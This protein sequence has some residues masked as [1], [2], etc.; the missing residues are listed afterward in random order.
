[1]IKIDFN[2]AE[3]IL[4]VHIDN[5]TTID[6]LKQE[7]KNFMSEFQLPKVLKILEIANA[8]FAK[9]PIAELHQH[10]TKFLKDNFS[11]FEMVKHAVVTNNPLIS[12]YLS[13]VVSE[14][15][16]TNY[17]IRLYSTETAAKHWLSTN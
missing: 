8:D 12:A 5:E 11:R 4:Y 1:M 15:K 17:T 13:L 16:G 9:I 10:I 2:E 14:L 6:E 7:S 3:Q